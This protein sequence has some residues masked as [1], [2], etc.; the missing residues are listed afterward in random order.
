MAARKERF[1]YADKAT[2]TFINRPSGR[3]EP[4]TTNSEPAVKGVLAN[5]E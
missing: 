4:L 1:I 3:L 5:R 2:L